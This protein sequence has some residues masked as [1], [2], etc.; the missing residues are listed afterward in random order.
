MDKYFYYSLN[1]DLNWAEDQFNIVLTHHLELIDILCFL[2]NTMF[3]KKIKDMPYKYYSETLAFKYA[4]QSLNL[5]TLLNGTRH[6][7]KI[8]NFDT[9]VFD[10]SSS[11]IMQRSLFETY[12]T[13]Y[14]LYIQPISQAESRCKWLIFQIAG[15][16]S[17]Q[18]FT[19]E[20]LDVRPKL[21]RERKEIENAINE[22]KTNQ[23]FL[24]LE[25]AKQ[26]E[27]LH[28]RQPKLIG[29]QTLF[30]TS[31]LKSNLFINPWKLYS[32]YAHSEY[33]SL[34]QFKDYRQDDPEFI[35][36]KQ[37]V[38]FST[39]ILTAVFITNMRK[40]YPEIEDNFQTLTKEQIECVIF[41]DGIARKL[42]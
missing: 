16:N 1:N 6:C 24:S 4:Y 10:I 31:D 17:R 41:F 29:W 26:K 33:L 5:N 38:A 32:N 20:Y 34:I 42:S 39:L 11:Y 22:L 25:E 14:Y 23:Y 30:K 19:S 15:L 40:L 37:S 3:E 35:S 13:F 9:I 18:G 7:S 28:K 36:A 27:I 21:E 2:A 12:L 8:F